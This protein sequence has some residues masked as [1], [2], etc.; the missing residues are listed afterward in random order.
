ML[1]QSRSGFAQMSRLRM[2]LRSA[3]EYDALTKG[4]KKYN[5]FRPGARKKVKKAFNKKERKWLDALLIEFTESSD[6][7]KSV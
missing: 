1:T 6:A 5:K 3:N 4:G 2:P 7:S